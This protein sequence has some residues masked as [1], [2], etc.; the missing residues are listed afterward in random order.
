MY[1]C[2]FFSFG[3]IFNAFWLSEDDS[4]VR[5][6]YLWLPFNVD[7][8]TANQMWNIAWKNDQHQTDPIKNEWANALNAAPETK[9]IEWK[10]ARENYHLC[11]KFVRFGSAIN[12]VSPLQFEGMRFTFLCGSN[13]MC[14][15]TCLCKSDNT[16]NYFSP[17]LWTNIAISCTEFACI[18]HSCAARSLQLHWFD[19]FSTNTHTSSIDYI[20]KTSVG[21][22]A[23]K[24]AAAAVRVFA[25]NVLCV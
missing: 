14:A 2:V 21:G 16:R 20:A 18:P 1:I 12:W 8:L 23:A 6:Q 7:R 5:F 19:F 15:S 10:C 24:V 4:C 22:G 13:K 11:T 3:F 17:F 9:Q 25:I